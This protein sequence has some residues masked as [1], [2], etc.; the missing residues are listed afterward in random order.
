M[1]GCARRAGT[2]RGVRRWL[3]S[4]LVVTLAVSLCGV[5]VGCRHATGVAPGDVPPCPAVLV[6]SAAEASCLSAEALSSLVNLCESLVVIRGG[7]IDE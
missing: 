3:N 4:R 6:E 5:S 7:D 2:R 1:S